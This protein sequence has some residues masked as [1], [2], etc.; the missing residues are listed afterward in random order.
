MPDG[1]P[2]LFYLRTEPGGNLTADGVQW[3]DGSVTVRWLTGATDQW[4]SFDDPAAAIVHTS[5]ATVVW[6]RSDI[7]AQPPVDPTLGADL[8]D[9]GV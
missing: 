8:L 5:D 1:I 3:P 4:A 9:T 6:R 7:Y 2:G